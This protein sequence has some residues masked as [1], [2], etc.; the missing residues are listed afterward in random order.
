M[1][2]WQA[3]PA[4]SSPFFSDVL[5]GNFID[6]HDDDNDDDDILVHCDNVLGDGR[7]S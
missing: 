7:V 6:G 1:D 5:V 4:F 3:C 2:R